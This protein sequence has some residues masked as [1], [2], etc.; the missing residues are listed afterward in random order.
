MLISIHFIVLFPKHSIVPAFPVPF[1]HLPLGLS[2]NII[3]FIFSSPILFATFFIISS[4]TTIK[5][6]GES[7]LPCHRPFYCSNHPEYS[8]TF[9]QLLLPLFISCAPFNVKLCSL[10][11]VIFYLSPFTLSYDFFSSLSTFLS[12]S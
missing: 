8:P 3:D 6:S 5:S 9:T 10:T 12:Y 4:I 1:D 2:T 11:S 7:A